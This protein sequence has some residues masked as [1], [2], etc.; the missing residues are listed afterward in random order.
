MNNNLINKGLYRLKQIINFISTQN[1]LTWWSQF[2]KC[3]V[4]KWWK[5]EASAFFYL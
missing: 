1:I 4:K 3:N 5:I 2:M